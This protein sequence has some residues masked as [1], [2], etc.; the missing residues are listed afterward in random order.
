MT[1]PPEDSDAW[2]ERRE[3]SQAKRA[4]NRENGARRLRAAGIEF[5]EHNAG[6]HLVVAGRY[7]Y[8]PGTGLWQA[9]GD[10]TQQRGVAR[11]IAR[12]RHNQG[13]PD[14]GPHG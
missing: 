8:W 2:R 1:T 7:D 11:L 9:R 12:I 10:R 4:S 13:R 14:D 6:A 5:T 3:A